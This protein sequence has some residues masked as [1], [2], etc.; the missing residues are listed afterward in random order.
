ML[1]RVGFHGTQRLGSME[2]TPGFLGTHRQTSWVPWNPS[3][4]FEGTQALGSLEPMP[5]F[6]EPSWFAA[7]FHGTQPWVPSN[8]GMGSMEPRRG[9]EE[10]NTLGK[11][12]KEEEGKKRGIVGFDSTQ[13]LDLF[14][15]GFVCWRKKMMANS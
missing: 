5:G 1:A 4:R 15:A 3:A 8:P 11:Q 13:V 7:G 10:P 12:G 2:P 9:F 14:G 6:F